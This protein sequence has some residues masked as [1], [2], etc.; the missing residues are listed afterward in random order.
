MMFA[1]R[2]ITHPLKPL[3]YIEWLL[4]LIVLL[5]MGLAPD[6]ALSIIFERD[7][8]NNSIAVGISATTPLFFLVLGSWLGGC[9]WSWRQPQSR[10]GFIAIILLWPL[11]LTPGFLLPSW[12]TII[13]EWLVLLTSGGLFIWMGT[14][15]SQQR[16][17]INQWLYTAT[18]F[19]LIWAIYLTGVSAHD[20]LNLES[21]LLLHVVA[22]IRAC[23]M[24][25]GKQRWLAVMLLF[26]SYHMVSVVIGMVWSQLMGLID[27]PVTLNPQDIQQILNVF[28]FN[29]TVMFTVTTA[30]LIVLVNT[31]VSERRSRDQLTQAHHQLRQY[32]Q[33]IENQTMLEERNRIARE[34]HDALGHTLTAQSIQLE[35]ALVYFPP[36]ADR[37]HQ[38]ITQ[39]KALSQT[40]LAEVRRSVSQLRNNFL[41]GK[42]FDQAVSD[43]LH[44]FRAV[45][46]CEL[47]YQSPIKQMPLEVQTAFYR[48]IQEALTNITRHSGADQ[49]ALAIT[50]EITAAEA[51]RICLKITDN[52][53]GFQIQQTSSGFGLQGMR[54]RAESIDGTLTVNSTPG[55]GCIVQVEVLVN[56]WLTSS[57]SL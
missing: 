25:S 17:R 20:S 26:S 54:E 55:Q 11:L 33:R 44:E 28:I 52:G 16:S 6:D 31:L 10:K 24:F 1:R 38:F 3:L 57:A 32:A 49:V 29:V 15:I 37:A 46:P 4:L 35:N 2:S 51:Q 48:I 13:Y 19:L 12:A 40:A 43:L 41:A 18:E 34:I 30:L 22:L 42:S 45:T 47:D 7:G 50:T 36:N 21:L 53:R 23:L 39:A 27:Q 14:Q 9:G 5:Y 8:V 56:S